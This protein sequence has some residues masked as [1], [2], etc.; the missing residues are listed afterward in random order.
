M[1]SR[2]PSTAAFD[3]TDPWL[4]KALPRLR[5]IEPTRSYGYGGELLHDDGRADME[6]YGARVA[7][8]ATRLGEALLS[9]GASAE[10][11]VAGMLVVAETYGLSYCEPG[12]TLASVSLSAHAPGELTPLHANRV[13]RKHA[14][15]FRTLGRIHALVERISARQLGLDEARAATA[16]ILDAPADR[17]RWVL[18]GV[19]PA[20]AGSRAWGSVPVQ[21]GFVAAGGGIAFGGG[22]LTSLC[23]FVAGLLGALLCGWLGRNGVPAFYRSAVAAMP[24][25]VLAVAISHSAPPATVQSVV[26]AGVLG[27]LPTV[28]FVS[29]VQDALTGHY[30]TALGRLFDALLVFAAVVTGVVAVL[31]VGRL[32][33]FEA[34][35][36][37]TAARAE[38][39]GAPAVGAAVFSVAVAARARTPRRDWLPAG[40]LGLGGFVVAAEFTVLGL[41]SLVGTAVVAAGVGCAAHA[42]A[43]R[44]RESALPLVVP[45]IAPLL[46]G[47]ALYVALA[48]LASGRTTEGVGGLVHA[49][50]VTLAIAVGVGLAGEAAQLFRRVRGAGAVSVASRRGGR[51]GAP[52]R[53]PRALVRKAGLNVPALRLERRRGLNAPTGPPRRQSSAESRAPVRRSN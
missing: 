53:T 37:P 5:G 27:L 7:E 2:T 35:V 11:A 32:V 29:A 34:P 4:T 25:A 36:V 18:N 42:V 17:G 14:T 46:P 49:A 50:A 31:G 1:P 47:S 24:A 33:G 51:H 41:P 10:E 30:L 39:L 8:L 20:R 6:A 28:T 52:P 9:Y 26:V 43:R 19:S 13:I 48:A 45:G 40:L 38:Y 12:V 44:R 21:T 3:R 23:A 15:D 16:R 22:A